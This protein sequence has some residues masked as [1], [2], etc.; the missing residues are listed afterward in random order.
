MVHFKA[1]TKDGKMM[2]SWVKTGASTH[3]M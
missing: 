3:K 1:A 2:A